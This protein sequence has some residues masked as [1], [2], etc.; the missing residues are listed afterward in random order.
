MAVSLVTVSLVAMS[1]V[2]VSLVAVSLVAARLLVAA[3]AVRVAVLEE[4]QADEVDAQP[5]A[6]HWPHIPSNV[7]FWG[8]GFFPSFYFGVDGEKSRAFG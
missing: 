3:V 7:N 1:L 4:E 6:A 5:D 2:T 8:G